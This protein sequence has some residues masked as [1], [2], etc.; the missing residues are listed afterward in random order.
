[1][2][3]RS[4]IT[5]SFIIY[6]Y[7]FL[8]STIYFYYLF[9]PFIPFVV[10]Y[11]YIKNRWIQNIINKKK[12]EFKRFGFY[13]S[14]SYSSDKIYFVD[15]KPTY[16][17]TTSQTEQHIKVLTMWFKYYT[18]TSSYNELQR[19]NNDTLHTDIM[20]WNVHITVIMTHMYM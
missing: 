18:P 5:F 10:I 6:F 3:V 12:Q 7:Y 17:H 1:M 19:V 9:I 4:C 14:Q 20:A 13:C 2:W 11:K 8:F 15:K 16:R